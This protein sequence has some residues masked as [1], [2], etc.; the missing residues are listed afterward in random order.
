[1]QENF[2]IT[3]NNG[4]NNLQYKNWKRKKR[5]GY[6]RSLAQAQKQKWQTKQQSAKN[7]SQ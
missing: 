1:M 6:G 5:T 3:W 7:Q 2:Y 4:K